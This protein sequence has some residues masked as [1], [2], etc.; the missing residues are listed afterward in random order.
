M[1]TRFVA[2]VLL[3]FAAAAA[4]AAPPTAGTPAPVTSVSG[5]AGVSGGVGTA[6]RPDPLTGPAE[7][8]APIFWLRTVPG[9]YC[10]VRG[11]L[12]PSL[13]LYSDGTVLSTDGIGAHCDPLP[14]VRIGW[15]D[16]DV[17]EARLAEYFASP[18]AAV[19]M[20]DLQVTDLP[21]ATLVHRP[22]GG[23]ERTVGLYGPGAEEY[24]DDLDIST[25]E[26]EARQAFSD[27][28]EGIRTDAA[29]A[30]NWQP[31]QLS[32]TRLAAD[33]GDPA[34]SALSWPLSSAEWR[35][36]LLDDPAA[37]GSAADD[38]CRAALGAEATELLAAHTGD[39]AGRWRTGATEVPVALGLVLPGAAPCSDDAW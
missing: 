9:Y 35:D 29:L 12:V 31:E 39:T 3:A 26:R 8:A 38:R 22:V 27:V 28:V 1:R 23:P 2:L 11:T 20:T 15:L 34:A 13:V 14:T 4:C 21:F 7:G 37:G 16:P 17:A 36:F 18:E 10:S 32:V 33:E 19:D 25:R 24:V 6:V 5:S 30:G